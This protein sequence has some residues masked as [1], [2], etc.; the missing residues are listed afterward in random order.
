[1]RPN[2]TKQNMEILDYIIA[3]PHH[4]PMTSLDPEIATERSIKGYFKN[5]KLTLL[6]SFKNIPV[7]IWP[8]PFLH[9][10][11]KFKDFY[12]EDYL[13]EIYTEC[14]E[15]CA[16]KGIALEI[17]SYWHRFSPKPNG[18]VNKWNPQLGIDQSVFKILDQ[19]YSLAVENSEETSCVM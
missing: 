13:R 9:E 18:I 1:M 3:G 4:Q 12:W 14:L 16:N 19:M 2:A 10:V 17:N 15:L 6:N 11:E 5:L 7:D 8:H